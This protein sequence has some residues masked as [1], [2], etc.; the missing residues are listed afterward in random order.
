MRPLADCGGKSR[1]AF[2]SGSMISV[3][4]TISIPPPIARPMRL[5]THT[6]VSRKPGAVQV[7]ARRTVIFS[8]DAAGV[9]LSALWGAPGW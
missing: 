4:A 5:I 7:L 3:G 8:R 1:A 9:R 6:L 2:G